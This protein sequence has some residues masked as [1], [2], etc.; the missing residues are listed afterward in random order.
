MLNQ[1]LSPI[2]HS[3]TSYQ[4]SEASS[5]QKDVVGSFQKG[6]VRF[7][8]FLKMMKGQDGSKLMSSFDQLKLMISNFLNHEGIKENEISFQHQDSSHI[9]KDRVEALFDQLKKVGVSGNELNVISSIIQDIMT[10]N[11]TTE[12]NT[13]PLSSKDVDVL[14]HKLG[15]ALAQG[16]EGS[17][18]IEPKNPEQP[19]LIQSKFLQDQHR[20]AQSINEQ[21]LNGQKIDPKDDPSF[22]QRQQSF[23]R[24]FFLQQEVAEKN[25]TKVLP[26]K[27][28]NKE[29][30]I[31]NFEKQGSVERKSFFPS[32]L[33]EEV[34]MKG[35][36]NL[37]LNDDGL[38]ISQ[39]NEN[40]S[41]PSAQF[42][43]QGLIGKKEGL[44]TEQLKSSVF[45]MDHMSQAAKANTEKI[46]ADVINHIEQNALGRAQSLDLTVLDRDLGQFDISVN[47]D[48]KSQGMDILIRA[49]APEGH[50]FFVENE[51]NLN[52]NLEQAGLKVSGLK[53]VGTHEVLGQQRT[54]Q[55]FMSQDQSRD[56]QKGGGRYQHD[57][58]QDQ[59]QQK[60]KDLWQFYK[61]R[62]QA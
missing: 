43:A 25:N 37:V 2:Q 29:G 49:N 26:F 58:G 57:Q 42:M 21:T 56:F 39:K 9:L 38:K 24:P 23:K 33:S 4:K 41:V 59:G 62:Y 54:Q 7:G 36:D 3:K 34:K 13:L 10:S 32:F 12:I 5:G 16:H 28:I 22:G 53:I 8:D 55:D 14:V 31:K 30:A 60:R 48:L 6:E 35:K 1:L 18:Q 61:E 17:G 40:L 52:R 50:K 47:K 15:V 27:N 45:Q 19:A 44:N 51:M 46:L 20:L 11:A